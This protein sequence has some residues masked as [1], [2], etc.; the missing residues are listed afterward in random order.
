MMLNNNKPVAVAAGENKQKY[1][2]EI[3][4]PELQTVEK[5][6]KKPS[7]PSFLSHLHTN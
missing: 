5:N 6:R 1:Q 7:Q 2:T 3:K 4:K